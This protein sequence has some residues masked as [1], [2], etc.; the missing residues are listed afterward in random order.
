MTPAEI[1][2][3][4]Q[5]SLDNIR[6]LKQ[7]FDIAFEVLTVSGSKED[8]RKVAALQEQIEYSLRALPVAYSAEQIGNKTRVYIG[9]LVPGMFHKFPKSIEHVYTHYPEREL[10]LESIRIGGQTSAEL[11]ELMQKNHVKL[12]E[13]T[14]DDLDSSDFLTSK[15]PE[16]VDVIKLTAGDLG[17]RDRS[18]TEE[19]YA[20]ILELGLEL[21]PPEVGPH[22]RLAHLDQAMDDWVNIGM[23]P[24]ANQGGCPYV[25]YVG[26]DS[27][28]LWLDYDW[29]VPGNTWGPDNHFLFRVLRGT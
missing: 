11:Q 25:F 22:Y 17:L 7:A 13:S 23:K 29:V 28:G 19:I 5:A 9:K 15:Q 4:S 14:K 2:A 1:C 8:L 12:S 10:Q 24:F 3:L 18:T 16:A 6:A 21:C 26:R 27:D 20:R